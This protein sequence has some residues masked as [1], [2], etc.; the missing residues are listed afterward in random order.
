MSKPAACARSA[1]TRSPS[2]GTSIG[3]T[4]QAAVGRACPTQR[5]RMIEIVAEELTNGW[6]LRTLVETELLRLD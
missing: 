1:S 2:S 5:A 3:C 6:D 4:L